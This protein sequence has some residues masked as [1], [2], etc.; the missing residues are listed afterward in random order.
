[1]RYFIYIVFLFSVLLGQTEETITLPKADVIEWA[2]R[3]QGFEKADSLSQIVISDLESVVLKL[4]ENAYMDSL[5]IEKRQLQMLL[6]KE[7][8]EL[9]KDKVKLV[10]PKWHENKWL[11]FVYGVSATAVSVNLAGQITN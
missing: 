5:I 6:L 3:L 11:W 7:T 1:M 10:K 8:N 2:N 9:Y 4:E